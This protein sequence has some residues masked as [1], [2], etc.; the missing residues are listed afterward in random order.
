MHHEFE[1]SFD[2]SFIKAGLRR[3]L[4][5]KGYVLAG[6]LLVLSWIMRMVQGFWEPIT[7]CAFVLGAVLVLWR[8]HCLLDR[9]AGRVFELW[10]D[11]SPDGVVRYELDDEGFSVVLEHGNSRFTWQGL[12]RLWRYNDVWLVEVVKAQSVFF[13]PDQAPAEVRDFIVERCQDAGVR[14]GP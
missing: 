10:R 6:M 14:V 11:Q 8:F 3:D 4:M 12:Q 9:I 2:V 1:F 13:P 7:T 5:W